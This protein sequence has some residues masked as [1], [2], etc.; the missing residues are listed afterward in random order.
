[1]CFTEASHVAL[2]RNPGPGLRYGHVTSMTIIK[3]VKTVSLLGMQALGRSLAVQLDCVR[4]RVFFETVY[5]DTH[6]KDLMW[7]KPQE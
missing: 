7:D 1:M 5:R 3:M 4:G 2:N 6:Y